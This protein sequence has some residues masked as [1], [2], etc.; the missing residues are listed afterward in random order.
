[1]LTNG[2][3]IQPAEPKLLQSIFDDLCSAKGFEH[4]SV[5]ATDTAAFLI[6]AYQNG[7]TDEERL[8]RL[9]GL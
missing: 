9:I 8:R 1:M 5:A 3:I 4:D 7:V 6:S 2:R